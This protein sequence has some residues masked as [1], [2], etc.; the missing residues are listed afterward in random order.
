VSDQIRTFS[1]NPPLA[2]E[3]HQQAVSA[4][5]NTMRRQIQAL[6]GKGILLSKKDGD[7]AYKAGLIYAGLHWPNFPNAYDD[8]NYDS[9]NDSDNDDD[10]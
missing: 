7:I 2:T 6:I 1:P 8:D 10:N 9:D 4:E 5:I 3:L